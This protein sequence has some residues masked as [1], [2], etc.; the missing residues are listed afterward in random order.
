MIFGFCN[1]GTTLTMPMT[2][3]NFKQQCM[4][5]VGLVAVED[6]ADHLRGDL[7]FRNAYSKFGLM[8]RK[9]YSVKVLWK[10]FPVMHEWPLG[11]LLRTPGPCKPLRGEDFDDSQSSTSGTCRS[12]DSRSLS[13]SSP[14]KPSLKRRYDSAFDEDS[15]N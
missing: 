7:Q 5:D 4:N 8:L 10:W 2:L 13:P 3:E 14:S 11:L 15:S 12:L 1:S 9:G 6:L